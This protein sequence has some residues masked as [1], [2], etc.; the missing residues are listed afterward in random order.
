MVT[1]WAY[2]ALMVEEFKSNKFEKPFFKYDME[3]SRTGWYNSFLL[4]MLKVKVEE[5]RVAGK[6]PDFEEDAR[7]N[8]RKLNFHL[9][10]LASE[11]GVH[12]GPWISALNYENFNESVSAQAKD[13]ID[14]LAVIIRARNKIFQDRRDSLVNSIV[15]RMGDTE[16][17]KLRVA[18]YN[19][20]LADIVL[21]RLGTIKIYETDKK[22]IQKADP[23]LMRPGSRYGR[24]HFY[25]PFKMLGNTVVDTLLFNTAAIW[26]MTIVLFVTLY[27][28]G[29]KRF[30]YF[31]ESL[32]IP[33]WRK[34]G[35]ELLPV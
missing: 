22:L 14:S 28:D 10:D 23:V 7:N 24:A 34:F 12:P 6:N 25:A 15:N 4:P 3:I 8:M 18:D 2:E 16:F 19:E 5:C 17:Q 31:L 21:N 1:R 20:T 11:T 27:F 32:R 30:I 33:I 29:L 26:L 13:Y 35:R 9:K